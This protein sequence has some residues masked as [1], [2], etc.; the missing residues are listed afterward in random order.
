MKLYRAPLKT[1]P[2]EVSTC[3]KFSNL[4]LSNT[5]ARTQT[6]NLFSFFS[7]TSRERSKSAPRS[8]LKNSKRASKNQVF[9]STVSK[10]PKGGP[11]WRAKRRRFGTLTSNQQN[12]KKIERDSLETLKIFRK[13]NS[14]PAK[15]LEN[16]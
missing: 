6:A 2:F 11:N 14:T 10:K 1:R 7:Q 9:S 16:S 13:K 12:I 5:T 15:K 4:H 8:R 3:N